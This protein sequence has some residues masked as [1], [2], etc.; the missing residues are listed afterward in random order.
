MTD[1][2]RTTALDTM[3]LRRTLGAFLTGVTVVTTIDEDGMSRGLTANSFTSVSLDPPLVLVCIAATAGSYQ[4][5]ERCESFAINV[6][7]EGQEDISKRFASPRPNKFEGLATQ[8]G[9]KGVP[10]LTDCLAWL[11]CATH[12]RIVVGDHMVLIGLVQGFDCGSHRPL[13]FFQGGYV[14]F[15]AEVQALSRRDRRVLIG[16]LVET[17]KGL[18]LSGRRSSS[19]D[20]QWTVPLGPP[21]LAENGDEAMREAA[22]ATLGA[23]AETAFLYSVV[24]I[25]ATGTTCLIYRARLLAPL[26]ESESTP[27]IRAFPPDEIPWDEIPD[28]HIRDMLH[29]YLRERTT[30]RFGIYAGD[31]KDG[32]VAVIGDQALWSEHARIV[33]DVETTS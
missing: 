24:D 4:A 27:L 25:P 26:P 11:D 19:G 33:G 5:F 15:G 29:R 32:Q 12:D 17:D 7:A 14:Q 6:L 16:W 28:S 10:V 31:V 3:A 21:G 13:G 22:Q 30:D 20:L 18:L 1:V 23:P 8:P 2:Q 9:A